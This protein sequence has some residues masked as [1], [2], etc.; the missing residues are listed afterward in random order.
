MS[1]RKE[2]VSDVP[3]RTLAR[4]ELMEEARRLRR[5]LKTLENSPAL[6]RDWRVVVHELEVQQEEVRIQNLQLMESQR[7]LEESRDRYAELYD[8]AP[9]AYI[10]LCEN[11]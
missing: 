8:F 3:L 9:V 5:K 1:R 2:A 11:G 10:S 6:R 4:A 7:L